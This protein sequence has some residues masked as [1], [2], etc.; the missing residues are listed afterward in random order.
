VDLNRLRA[1]VQAVFLHQTDDA[2]PT[3]A[4]V[5]LDQILVNARAPVPLTAFVE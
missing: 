2:L 3:D 1:R 4:L 5:L